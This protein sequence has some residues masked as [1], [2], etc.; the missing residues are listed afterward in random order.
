M[1]I[2]VACKRKMRPEKNGIVWEEMQ[3]P[4]VGYKL[5]QA[6][7]WKCPGCDCQIITGSAPTA[8]VEHFED[9]Y[10]KYAKEAMIQVVD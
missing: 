6:D 5:Y 7:L 3:G 10:A 4:G 2:C 9:H 8:F 1:P